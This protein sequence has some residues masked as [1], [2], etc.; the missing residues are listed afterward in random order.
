MHHPF[1]TIVCFDLW[2][3]NIKKVSLKILFSIQS[4][5]AAQMGEFIAPSPLHRLRVF[6]LTFNEL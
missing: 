1:N 4:L 3:R 6:Y 2:R 5:F